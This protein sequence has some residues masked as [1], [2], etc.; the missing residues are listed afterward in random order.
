[1]DPKNQ[2]GMAMRI[3]D[4]LLPKY[5]QLLTDLDDEA[6]AGLLAGSPYDA[7]KAMAAALVTRYHGADAAEAQVAE[8]ARVFSKGQAPTDL[9]EVVV[10]APGEDGLWW[11]VDLLKACGFAK[12]TSQ[13]RQLVDGGGVRLGE[14]PIS[15]WRARIDVA[16]GELFRASNRKQARLK[17]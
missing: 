6:I 12:S 15:D 14:T 7:K 2:F 8:W 4:D 13:A 17:R 1:D 5:L 11:V 9:P 16:G 3:G 10:P